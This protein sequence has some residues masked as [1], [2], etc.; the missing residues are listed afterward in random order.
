MKGPGRDT[1]SDGTHGHDVVP[2]SR[3]TLLMDIIV[4]GN[5]FAIT[6]LSVSV[7]NSQEGIAA[8]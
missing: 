1:G 3:N 2:W 5:P 6:H 8:T 4:S 7:R